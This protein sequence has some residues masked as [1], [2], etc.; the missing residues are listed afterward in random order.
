MI[1]LDISYNQ[2]YELDENW[3]HF[4]KLKHLNL[5]YN[6]LNNIPSEIY[7]LKKLEILQINFNNLIEFILKVCL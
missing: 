3:F 5:D 2:F 7:H 4:P 1:C 6:K